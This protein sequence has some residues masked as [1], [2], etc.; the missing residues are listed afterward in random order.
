MT[1]ALV[2]W[3]AERG[4]R[5]A[6][7]PGAVLD[8]ARSDIERR[9]HDGE[10]DPELYKELQFRYLDDLDI[11]EV[12]SVIVVVVPRPAHVIT[13]ELGSERLETLVPPTY[14]WYPDV[15]RRT[16]DSLGAVLSG[17]CALLQSAPLK[18]I[19]SR[20]GLVAYGRNNITYA[21]GLGSYYQ[22]VACVTDVDLAP[23]PEARTGAPAALSACD[24]CKICRDACPTGAIGDDRFLLRA[25]RCLTMFNERPDPWPEWM[26][27]SAHNCLLGCMLCQQA[28]PRNRGLLRI[29]PVEPA[30]TSEET[31]KILEGKHDNNDGLWRRI[32]TKLESFA[33]LRSF[34]GQVG[35]NLAALLASKGV[36]W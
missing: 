7:G 23:N 31:S 22:L 35:R 14:C 8:E 33:G 29:E 34:E 28:C 6:W 30:F 24:K 15:S 13:F 25:E 4:Y 27:P 5:I 2:K 36:K 20:L 12:K 9:R 17:S 10:I 19:A 18:A 1:G 3:A 21:P 16:A 11:R 32:K 26:S